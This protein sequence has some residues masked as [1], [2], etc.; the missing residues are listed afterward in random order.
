VS[1]P[2]AVWLLFIT[3]LFLWIAVRPAATAPWKVLAL[4]A[5]FMVEPFSNAAMNAEKQAYPLKYDYFLQAIDQSL[6]L[7]A[8]AVARHFSA[9]QREVLLW[10][11]QSLSLSMVAWYVL[12]LILENGT[13]RRLLFAYMLAY[14]FGPL[15]YLVV[16]ACGPR[17]AFG[18]AFPMG[19]P[20]F[21][22]S[23]VRLNFWPNAMPSL[24]VATSLLFALF[25]AKNGAIRV[26]GY[27]YLAGTILATLA[28]EHYVIDLIVGLPYAC[29][30]FTAAGKRISLAAGYFTM[31]LAWL[32]AIRTQTPFLI[33]HPFLLRFCAALTIIA[34]VAATRERWSLGGKRELAGVVTA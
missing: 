28:F 11:Y 25:P 15:M 24:H 27:I 1:V 30:A 22:V 29:F 26:F 32:I 23:L 8:F 20:S 33:T 14:F 2:V 9:W 21:P 12:Q 3:G 34:A 16:P 31:V 5:F 18:D 6:G 10:I 19:H 13:P 7:T 4:I 17:H